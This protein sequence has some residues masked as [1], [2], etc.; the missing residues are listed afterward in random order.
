MSGV[1]TMSAQG[2]P[3]PHRNPNDNQVHAGGLIRF[4]GGGLTGC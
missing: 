1:Q 2:Y 3:D 4:L